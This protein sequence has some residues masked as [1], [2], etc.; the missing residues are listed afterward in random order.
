MYTI[1]CHDGE[2]V[3][4]QNLLEPIS[5]PHQEPLLTRQLFYTTVNYF[6]IHLEHTF[7]TSSSNS[8]TFDFETPP[9][10][11]IVTLTP[12]PLLCGIGIPRRSRNNCL[13]HGKLSVSS[14]ALLWESDC[15]FRVYIKKSRT[16]KHDYTKTNLF[17]DYSLIEPP[18]RIRSYINY[19]VMMQTIYNNIMI[20]HIILSHDRLN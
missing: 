9:H 2:L 14:G 17:S 3:W 11:Y 13:F 1:Y 15:F 12:S 19:L 16:S 20:I 5:K 7:L 18:V 4:S 10:Q 6:L 8:P